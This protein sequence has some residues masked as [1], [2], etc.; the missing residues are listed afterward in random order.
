MCLFNI[1]HNHK[2]WGFR[3]LSFDEYQY[4]PHKDGNKNVI[5]NL[6]MLQIHK[7]SSNI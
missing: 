3:S 6:Y 7:L 2:I 5:Y 1:L 4:N